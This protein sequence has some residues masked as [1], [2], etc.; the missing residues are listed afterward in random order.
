MKECLGAA[1][2]QSGL[3]I[4]FQRL[5]LPGTSNVGDV[6][7]LE[8]GVHVADSNQSDFSSCGRL[9]TYVQT[10]VQTCVV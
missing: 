8:N 2:V 3:K 9:Q 5:I 7:L 1:A 4:P 10:Y 6:L